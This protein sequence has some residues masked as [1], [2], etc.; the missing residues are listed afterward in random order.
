MS[1]QL[2]S[3]TLMILPFGFIVKVNYMA[4]ASIKWAREYTTPTAANV[5]YNS[6]KR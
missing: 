3:S 6:N 4:E 2:G 1:L 5:V